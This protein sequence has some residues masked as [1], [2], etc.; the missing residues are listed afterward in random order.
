MA[1]GVENVKHYTSD[2]THNPVQNH[3]QNLVLHDWLPPS[4]SHL[5]DSVIATDKDRCVSYGNCD[6][7]LFKSWLDDSGRVGE[8]AVIADIEL[9]CKISEDKEREDLK[10]DSCFHDIVCCSNKRSPVGEGRSDAMKDSGQLGEP[11]IS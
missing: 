3:K 10:W 2:N 8:V 7:G 4:T 6:G 11:H 1:T 5:Y 9:S